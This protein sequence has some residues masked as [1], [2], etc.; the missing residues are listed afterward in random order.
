LQA[1]KQ[2]IEQNFEHWLGNNEQID[3]VLLIGLWISN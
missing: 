1:Q 3:D 2:Q